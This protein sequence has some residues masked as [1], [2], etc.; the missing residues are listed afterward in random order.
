MYSNSWGWGLE[1]SRG[2][3]AI[4]SG[5]IE[6]SRVS[7]ELEKEPSFLRFKVN[8]KS[9]KSKNRK[10]DACITQKTKVELSF[11]TWCYEIKVPNKKF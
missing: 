1:L 4:G 5:K 7:R 6:L 2:G 11:A 9:A 8:S 3:K 10:T